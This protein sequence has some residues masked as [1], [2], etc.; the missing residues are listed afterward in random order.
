[1]IGTWL[2]VDLSAKRTGMK[3]LIS[4]KELK[5]SYHGHDVLKGVDLDVASGATTVV[6]GRSGCGK[7]TLLRCLNGLESFDSGS[8][9]VAGATI[10]ITEKK[11]RKSERNF[12]KNAKK[13]RSNLGMVFQ[14]F[15]LFPHLT[16]L[17]NMIKA[18]MVVK[19][20]SRAE[21]EQNAEAL[22]KK[23]GLSQCLGRYPS[24][25]S[26]GQQQRGAIARALAMSPRVILY[27]EPTSALDPWLV[28]EVFQV[29][30][31]LDAEGMT[32]VVVTHELR[33]AREVAD[34]VVF[35]EDGEIVEI[36]KAEQ[37]FS[38]PRDERTRQYLGRFL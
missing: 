36:G 20:I 3:P 24:Q 7:S 27:D 13:I 32:Q 2:L 15:N 4:V 38:Q 10:E 6:I 17:E 28:D 23:V 26:G 31:D 11:H 30:K 18:P 8:I 9:T 21:A 22:L 5:K 16:L 12:Q 1:M 37:I 34:E 35:I 33:F 25:L 19:N 14:S 29:M